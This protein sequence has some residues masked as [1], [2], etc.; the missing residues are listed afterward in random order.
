MLL[1]FA[2]LRRLMPERP[3]LIAAALFAIHPAQAEPV[4]SIFARAIVLATVLCLASLWLWLKGRHWAATAAFGVALL[5]KEE[6]VAFPLFLLLLTLSISR[7]RREFV[8]VGAMLGLSLAA[9]MRVLLAT[10]SVEGAGFGASVSP[11]EYWLAQGVAIPRYLQLLVLPH[12]F[13]VDP[14]ISVAGYGAVGWLALAASV[15]WAL[16]AF[17]HAR[18][19]F[20]WI[21]GLV[22]L[23]PSS[24]I[25]PAD[26]LAA[27]RRLYLP[28]IAWAPVA[29]L[30]L[31][32]RRLALLASLAL[33]LVAL[34]VGRCTVWRSEQALWTEAARRAPEKVRPR[35]HLARLAPPDRAL[36][37]LEE[38]RQ[39]APEDPRVFAELGRVH[40]ARRDPGAALADF[41]RALALE[42]RNPSAWNNRGL[43]FLLLGDRENAAHDFRR[44]LEIDPC[45]AQARDN[46]AQVGGEPPAPCPLLDKP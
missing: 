2:A 18:L 31:E 40:L 7:N 30:A 8:P 33:A 13:T 14:A 16:R 20:W 5:A 17:P 36:A 45:H 24:S 3:A 26:D 9:G 19:G 6:C 10:R 29:G 25:F 11:F 28:L 35:I 46:L 42:P 4:V 39:Q 41:G 32:R 43:A 44:A 34:S 22:L 23:L 1:L 15:V 12:G 27:D 38:A 21:A 37:I